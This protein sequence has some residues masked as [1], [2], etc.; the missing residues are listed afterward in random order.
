MKL[1]LLPG[2]VSKAQ[3]SK[4][5][6]VLMIVIIAL[7][8]GFTFLMINKSKDTLSSALDQL[9][10]EEAKV[11]KV[12]AI[13]QSA[14]AIIAQVGPM[15]RNLKLVKAMEEHNT[16]YTSLYRN[17]LSYV[18]DFYRI[19]NLT[20]TPTGESCT[21]NMTGVLK[22]ETQYADL[23]ISLFRIPNVT[24]V[25]RAGYNYERD[26]IPNLNLNDQEG[27][28]IK[29]GETNLPSDPIDNMNAMIQRAAN[30]PRG[31]LNQGQFGTGEGPRGAMPKWS[32]VNITL[33]L[34]KNIQT[35]DPRS[36]IEQ[37]VVTGAPGTVG[38]PGAN[39]AGFGGANR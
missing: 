39:T 11:K 38:R 22:T 29:Q 21:I 16:V 3:G 5:S 35:P 1:N 2:S 34:T 31:F 20:A 32:T 33:L 8:S 24:A 37:Q 7:A 18:P 15:D 19:T 4:A 6:F 23:A 13:S 10:P 12:L 9:P 25:T 28:R 30:K 26:F 14:D 36:T 17:I 27:E